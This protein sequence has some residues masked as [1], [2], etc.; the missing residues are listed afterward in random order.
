MVLETEKGD[1]IIWTVDDSDGTGDVKKPDTKSEEL[2]LEPRPDAA[3][4]AG[5]L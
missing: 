1:A 2:D 4:K 3:R 5:E